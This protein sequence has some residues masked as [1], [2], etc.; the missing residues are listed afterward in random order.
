MYRK[1]ERQRKKKR[2]VIS[3]DLRKE[4]ENFKNILNPEINLESEKQKS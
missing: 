3:N 2:S 4:T 1:K